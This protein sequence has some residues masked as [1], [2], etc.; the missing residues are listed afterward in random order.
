MYNPME[1]VYYLL[2]RFNLSSWACELV[3]QVTLQATHSVLDQ[4]ERSIIDP[5]NTI[6][7][8][9]TRNNASSYDD[10]D[11]D[12]GFFLSS[13]GMYFDLLDFLSCVFRLC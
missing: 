1:C 3:F 2:I 5:I 8:Y 13:C 9:P 10:D 4:M 12:Y 7:S 11:F 6:Q